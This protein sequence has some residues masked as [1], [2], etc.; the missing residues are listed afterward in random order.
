MRGVSGWYCN[1]GNYSEVRSRSRD[2]MRYPI[3]SHNVYG[4]WDVCYIQG[5]AK[6]IFW[7]FDTYRIDALLRTHNDVSRHAPCLLSLWRMHWPEIHDRVYATV[8][9]CIVGSEAYCTYRFDIVYR[10]DDD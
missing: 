10:H 1:V 2:E 8:S 6:V 7:A 9:L 5:W 3:R 4:L